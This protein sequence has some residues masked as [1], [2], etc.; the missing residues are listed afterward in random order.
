MQ[1]QLPKP[2][3]ALPGASAENGVGDSRDGGGRARPGALAENKLP[4]CRGS[5]IR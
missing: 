5:T 2:S 4:S 1:E 3:R